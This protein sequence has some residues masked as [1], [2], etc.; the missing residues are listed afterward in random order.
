MKPANL[1]EMIL[2]KKGEFLKLLQVNA[3][4]CMKMPLH[5]STNEAVLIVSKEKAVLSV[6][7][8]KYL[9]QEG[10]TIAIPAQQNH[11]L[12]IKSRPIALII[13]PSDSEIKFTEV[14]NPKLTC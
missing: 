8:K 2:L 5:Y 11:T 9:L 3:K 13:V 14:P 7:R 12:A 10:N 6:N 1:P 4:A